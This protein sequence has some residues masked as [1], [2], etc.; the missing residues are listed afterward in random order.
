MNKQPHENRSESAL[1]KCD[2][3]AAMG[4]ADADLH[5]FDNAIHAMLLCDVDGVVAQVNRRAEFLLG[6]SRRE[7]VVR[8]R[9]S[10][11]SP[12]TE[13]LV[14]SRLQ[15]SVANETPASWEAG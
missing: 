3:S 15:Q 8:P 14:Q 9:A 10:L 2:S 12:V 11:F 1:Q 6:Y 7:I 5:F 4:F 13:L